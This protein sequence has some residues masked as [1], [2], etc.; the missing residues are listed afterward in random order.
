MKY[1]VFVLFFGFTFTAFSANNVSEAP[2]L[3]IVAHLEVA[4][5]K[6]ESETNETDV[7][8]AVAFECYYTVEWLYTDSPFIKKL[9]A[10]V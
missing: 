3:E 2:P 9:D 4:D 8:N 10:L 5:N 7:N 1:F 6:I